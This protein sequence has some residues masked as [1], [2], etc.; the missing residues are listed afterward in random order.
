MKNLRI[1]V[2]SFALSLCVL[3]AISQ[4]NL[5]AWYKLDGNASDYSGNSYNGTLHGTTIVPDRLGNP[6]SAMHFNGTSD[7]IKLGSDFDYSQRTISLWLKIENFPTS[8]GAVYASDNSSL[9]YGMTGIT[10]LK[11]LGIN[12]INNKPLSILSL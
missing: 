3:S 7:Y 6:N 8:A 12:V 4:P 1:I 2:I 10:V 11:E 5:V 9:Q